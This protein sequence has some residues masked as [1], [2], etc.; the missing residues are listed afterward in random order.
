MDL[1]SR[2]S[3]NELES[4]VKAS[5]RQSWLGLYI[6]FTTERE[7]VRTSRDTASMDMAHASA[8]GFRQLSACS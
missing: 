4:H 2:W 3:S 7:R 5:L 1:H 6:R 8:G